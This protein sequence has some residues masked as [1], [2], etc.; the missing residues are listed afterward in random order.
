MADLIFNAPTPRF[1]SDTQLPQAVGQ[2]GAPPVRV[3]R[4][5]ESFSQDLN[6]DRYAEEGGLFVSR[7]ATLGTGIAQ[8]ANTT[9]DTTKPFI[10]GFN[11]AAVGGKS[12]RLLRLLMR[13]TAVSS[14][15]TIQN[16]SVVT[17]AGNN[18]SSAGTD[19][20]IAVSGLNTT[21]GYV[22]TGRAGVAN[23]SI[24]SVLR[25]GVPV[26]VLGTSPKLQ[27][28]FSPRTTTIPVIGDEYIMY[29]GQ[30]GTGGGEISLVQP[31]STTINRYVKYCDPVIVDAQYSFMIIPWAASIAGAM[32]WE[33]EL[34]WG[35]R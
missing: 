20:N 34:I 30:R 18:Y 4:Y 33:Y 24:L 35:E 10:V 6:V 9:E 2:A 21:V 16:I 12:V 26:T 1:A 29:F 14:S 23:A 8:T 17:A 25:V 15:Q 3:D 7:N 5:G 22:N 31:V 27:A 32:S 11:N 19:Y 13:P 28:K